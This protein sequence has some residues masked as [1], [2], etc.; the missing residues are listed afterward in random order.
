[1]AVYKYLGFQRVFSPRAYIRGM[2]PLAR[3]HSPYLAMR[4]ASS[5]T[6]KTATQKGADEFI[7]SQGRLAEETRKTLEKSPENWELL[8]HFTENLPGETARGFFIHLADTLSPEHLKRFSS[9][10][11]KLVVLTPDAS[12]DNLKKSFENLTLKLPDQLPGKLRAKGE[13]F[14]LETLA[15]NPD[16]QAALTKTVESKPILEFAANP[17]VTKQASVLTGKGFSPAQLGAWLKEVEAEKQTDSLRG[18]EM[19]H[20]EKP[21][22]EEILKLAGGFDEDWVEKLPAAMEIAR[23]LSPT[24]PVSLLNDLLSLSSLT[25]LRPLAKKTGATDWKAE[26]NWALTQGVWDDSPAGN[27]ANNENASLISKKVDLSK[28][29]SPRLTVG[30]KHRLQSWDDFVYLEASTNDKDWE[31]VGLF[32]DTA[33][34]EKHFDLGS[35]AGK[36]VKIRFRLKTDGSSNYEGFKLKFLRLSAANP[37][38]NKT[39]VPLFFE[40]DESGSELFLKQYAES[41]ATARKKLISGLKPI[42]E[43]V[44]HMGSA[45]RLMQLTKGEV[46]SGKRL[47]ELARHTDLQTA[48]SVFAELQPAE[49]E[50]VLKHWDTI[51]ALHPEGSSETRR[52]AFRELLEMSLSP[53]ECG[54]LEQ[55]VKAG[56]TVQHPWKTTGGWAAAPD[57]K[58]GLAWLDSPSGNYGRGSNNSLTSRFVD[59]SDKKSA[60]LTYEVDHALESG[61]DFLRVEISQDGKNWQQVESHTG[62]GQNVESRIDLEEYLGSRIQFRFRLTSDDSSHY[63]GASLRRI[64]LRAKNKEGASETLVSNDYGARVPADLLR[65]LSQQS[66]ED[67]LDALRRIQALSGE[68]LPAGLTLFD[69][70]QHVNTKSPEQLRSL[71]ALAH[72]VGVREAIA[73]WPSINA[74]EEVETAVQRAISS[75]DLLLEALDRE[76][77]LPA[78]KSGELVAQLLESQPTAAEVKGLR[79]LAARFSGGLESWE[80]QGWGRELN[81]EYGSVVTESPGGSYGSNEKKFLVSPRVR[82]GENSSLEFEA[83]NKLESGD[84]WVSLQIETGKDEWQSLRHYTGTK[85]WETTKIDL[86]PFANKR[87]RFRFKF[88]SD[89]STSY[90]GFQ[91]GQVRLDGKPL[92]QGGTPPVADFV[93]LYVDTPKKERESLLQRINALAETGGLA[94]AYQ[95]HHLAKG[96]E[97]AKGLGELVA[98]VGVES[99][100]EILESGVDVSMALASRELHKLLDAPEQPPYWLETAQL[101][102]GFGLTSEAMAPLVEAVR[103]EEIGPPQLPSDWGQEFDP[104]RGVVWSDSPGTTHSSNENNSLEIGEF[105]LWQKKDG[106][107]SFDLKTDLEENDDYLRVETKTGDDSWSSLGSFTGT[108]DWANQKISL[109]GLEG[110]RFRLRFRLTSDG[111]TNKDGAKLTRIR[112][113]AESRQGPVEFYRFEPGKPAFDTLIEALQGKDGLQK[114]ADNLN[115]LIQMSEDFGGLRPALTVWPLVTKALAGPHTEDDMNLIRDLTHSKGPLAALQLGSAVAGLEKRPSDLREKLDSLAVVADWK[116]SDE[117]L[118]WFLREGLKG[119]KQDAIRE[120]LEQLGP[121][122][123]ATVLEK[124]HQ[125]AGKALHQRS[126]A[127]VLEQVLTTAVLESEDLNAA[128]DEFLAKEMGPDITVGEGEIEI[129]GQVL[130]VQN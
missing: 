14:F 74:E 9:R 95:L 82:L 35:Y 116:L 86:T 88:T 68:S 80:S 84:D 17:E 43:G 81:S 78:Q 71:G 104:D 56:Q 44:G 114:P 73:I 31:R 13:A 22:A 53:E 55:I 25:P 49:Q 28:L 90:D 115:L 51:R 107:L 23:G 41:S 130:D 112:L 58:G 89:S 29:E 5:P 16:S 6:K 118:Q 105:S 91:L 39:E 101:L 76:S 47:A 94:A 30:F 19:L 93:K 21:N 127:K 59:L 119:D 77:A 113:G 109:E 128:L 52:K 83:A 122:K 110:R 79:E 102:E 50:Q 2:L 129:G 27:Y 67:R 60:S 97:D 126:L 26:G 38:T 37:E 7:E 3:V 65:V 87:V 66:P 117:A 36:K 85:N 69:Q 64:A 96:T 42:L 121:K 75:R 32:T 12:L 46:E 34:G 100:K 70:L 111:S 62:T 33:E 40:G 98:K 10:A 99:A 125:Q 4:T 45:M 1:M 63:D 120:R 48:E 15:Q 124:F 106:Y 57:S 20:A 54:V 103:A 8:S 61:D 24:E 72:Q 18:L 123:G 92:L 108:K 11:K